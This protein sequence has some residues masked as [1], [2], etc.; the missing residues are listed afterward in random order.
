M[1]Y[2]CFLY[3]QSAYS[4]LHS[5][6]ISTETRENKKKIQEFD[7]K[8][9]AQS[10]WYLRK[11]I[12]W[13]ELTRMLAKREGKKPNGTKSFLVYRATYSYRNCK[14]NCFDVV[15]YCS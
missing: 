13:N 12:E 2:P 5:Y 11:R 3:F 8:N 9:D 14:I 6:I 4:S 1:W 7:S 10:Q 15:D